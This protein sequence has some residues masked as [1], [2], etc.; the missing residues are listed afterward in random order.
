MKSLRSLFSP[1]GVGIDFGTYKSAIAYRAIFKPEP[2]MVVVR[3]RKII[4]DEY[5]KQTLPTRASLSIDGR[6]GKLNILIDDGLFPNLP[7][8]DDVFLASDF[9]LYIGTE[10]PEE[11]QEEINR[12]LGRSISTIGLAGKVIDTLR[13]AFTLNSKKEFFRP[14]TKGVVITIPPMWTYLQ[15]RATLKA[16]YLAGITNVRMIEEP[17]A[18]AAYLYKKGIY[19][20][21]KSPISVVIDFGAGTCDIALL[22]A[23]GDR[24]H[25]IDTDTLVFG[26]TNIDKAMLAHIVGHRKNQEYQ[27]INKTLEK[28]GEIVDSVAYMNILDELNDMKH[29]FGLPSPPREIKKHARAS[30]IEISMTLDDFEELVDDELGTVK[31]FVIEFLRQYSVLAQN[32]QQVLLVGGSSKLLGF[33]ENI[34]Q[35]IKIFTDLNH[36]N[37]T[38]VEEPEWCVAKGAAFV[39]FDDGHPPFIIKTQN[40][41]EITYDNTILSML[42]GEFPEGMEEELPKSGMVFFRILKDVPSLEFK[43]FSDGIPDPTDIVTISP[44]NEPN[45]K[46]DDRISVEYEIGIDKLLRFMPDAFYP[47]R[48]VNHRFRV[49]QLDSEIEQLKDDYR[50]EGEKL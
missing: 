26:G 7:E 33:R 37:I 15:R 32:I 24:I 48:E 36:L 43:I 35:A 27:L 45:F 28:D 16:T 12:I 17:L 50:I 2:E 22:R 9:K 40:I 14:K 29:E 13:I 20:P 10:W 34:E 49:H 39:S 25:V 5:H 44:K 19:K 4:G 18:A 11:K 47:R 6:S 21:N 30:K 46:E 1:L 31:N 8:E 38:S 41:P 23:D 42:S 3:P